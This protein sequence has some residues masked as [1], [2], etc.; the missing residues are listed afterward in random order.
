[1]TL[2]GPHP[3]FRATSYPALSRSVRIVNPAYKAG[4]VVPDTKMNPAD[5]TDVDRGGSA[6]TEGCDVVGYELRSWFLLR[7]ERNPD[8]WLASDRS[9]PLDERI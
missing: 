9:V 6:R 3:P 4:V 7:E 1:M 5:S 8:A 2:S